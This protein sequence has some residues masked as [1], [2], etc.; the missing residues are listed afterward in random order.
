M[1]NRW[2]GRR[3][4]QRSYLS[5]LP[6]IVNGTVRQ[7]SAVCQ[8]RYEDLRLEQKPY[9][10]IRW[11]AATDKQGKESTIPIRAEVRRALA[12][13]LA[14]RPGL[15]AHTCFLRL[16]D[17]SGRLRKIGHAH[18]SGLPRSWRDCLMR[19][20]RD[21]MPFVVSG[22]RNGS[23]CPPWTWLPQEGGRHRYA[24]SLLPAG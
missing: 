7:I 8:L 23:I 15:G 1:E 4:A 19:S 17:R 3:D 16:R 5:E 12:Q 20:G 11:P 24:R 22:L 18:G 13:I 9:G 2:E 6:D 21:F 14:E 10:A